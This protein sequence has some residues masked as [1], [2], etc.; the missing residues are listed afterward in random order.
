MQL[1][2]G[3]VLLNIDSR[4]LGQLAFFIKLIPLFNKARLIDLVKLSGIVKGL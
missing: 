2:I 4:S 1:C 3:I